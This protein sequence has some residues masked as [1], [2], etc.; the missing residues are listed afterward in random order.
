MAAFVE[1]NK[2]FIAALGPF[3]MEV[4]YLTTPSN[5]DTVTTKL[6]NPSF[7]VAL[8][9]GDAGGTNQV[10]AALSGKTVTIHDPANSQ[11]AVVIVF[12]DSINALST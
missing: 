8:M 5:G 2:G 1:G 9:T 11:N 12:G 3:K 6:A 7:A 4:I 10:S